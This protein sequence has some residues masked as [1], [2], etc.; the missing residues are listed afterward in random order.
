[1]VAD[2]QPVTLEAF[3]ALPDDGN[4]HEFVRG[5]VRVMPPP[6]GK[7]GFVE[8]AIIGAIDRYLYAQALTLGWEPGQ[9]LRARDILVG[10]VGGGEL[11]LRFAVP[12]DPEMVRGAD[13]AFIPAEQLAR[14]AWDGE[15]YFP[16]VPALVIEVIGETDRAGAVAEKV[17]DY[18]A[19]GAQRV[20]CVYPDLRAIH[21]HAA[22]APLRVIRGDAVATDDLLPDFSLPLNLVFSW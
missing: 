6:K 20:W 1:M 9:G 5:E 3:L 14:I 15:Q 17:Q 19:G 10:Q 18:L 2:R 13:I 11:G 22:D 7:H 4:R 8:A 12:D 21:I 16:S